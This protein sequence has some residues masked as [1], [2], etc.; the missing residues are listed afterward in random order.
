MRPE[1]R[2]RPELIGQPIGPF[3]HQCLTEVVLGHGPS[4]AREA[5]LDAAADFR[6][7]PKL[8]PQHFG[9]NVPVDVV[10]RGT[11]AAGDDNELGSVHCPTE[12]GS[13]AF[14][15]VAH[16][17]FVSDFDAQSIEFLGEEER[18]GVHPL[19][20]EQLGSHGDNFGIHASS[21]AKDD[22]RGPA[23]R[24]VMPGPDSSPA[25]YHWM[26][27]LPSMPMYNSIKDWLVAR[28]SARWRVKARPTM[29]FPETT[30]SAPASGVTRTIPRRP[31]SEDAT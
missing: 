29:P 2:R 13:Q 20:R 27:G 24:S 30:S 3:R 18:V 7:F 15:L 4:E 9:Q 8:P 21:I 16:D 11:E 19:G 5:F 17:R 26:R 22:G 12:H 23:P 25:I 14:G 31:P 10:F 28:I 1:A 6:D